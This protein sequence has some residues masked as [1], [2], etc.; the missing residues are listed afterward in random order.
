MK[1]YK[2]FLVVLLQVL[3]VYI[4]SAGNAVDLSH[5]D[6][7]YVNSLSEKTQDEFCIKAFGDLI[8]KYGVLQ[9]YQGKKTSDSFL[10][11][12]SE[13][14]VRFQSVINFRILSSSQSEQWRHTTIPLY[15]LFRVLLL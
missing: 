5:A 3:V 15:L 14:K 9:E 12:F 10:K 6:Y 13:K 11:Y 4:V 2:A 8:Y 1:R 7:C